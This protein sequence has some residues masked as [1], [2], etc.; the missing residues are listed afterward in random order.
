MTRTLVCGLLVLAA[1]FGPLAGEA[2]AEPAAAPSAAGAAGGAASVSGDVI[3]LA[4]E[5]ARVP[6]GVLD[7]R[8]RARH[9]ALEA[10][11]ARRAQAGA[12]VWIL[13]MPDA[14]DLG[15]ALAQVAGRVA[16]GAPDIVVVAS[17]MG[18]RARVPALAGAPAKIDAA[19]EASRRELAA[20]LDAGI[21]AFIARLEEARDAERQ[22]ERLVLW[23]LAACALVV[24]LGTLARWGRFRNAQRGWERDAASA[25]ARRVGACQE[26]LHALASAGDP[27]YDRLYAELKELSARAPADAAAGLDEL[28]R[29]LDAGGTR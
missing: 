24:L 1:I 25:H 19:F 18:V 28:A 26:K 10:A 23:G 8:D 12:K 3:A 27:T 6:G 21:E 5:L 29:K 9:A 15:S 2:M 16:P 14:A 17:R 20:D 13:L 7:A 22:S 4:G 11:V